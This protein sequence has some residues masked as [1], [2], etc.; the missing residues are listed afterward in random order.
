MVMQSDI[1]PQAEHGS[2]ETEIQQKK[3]QFG[4]Y[5]SLPVQIHH[6]TAVVL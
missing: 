6:L 3:K 5:I 2:I 1:K 4:A